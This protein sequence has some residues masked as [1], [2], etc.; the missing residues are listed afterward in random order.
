MVAPATAGPI[1]IS[2]P[3][4]AAAALEDASSSNPGLHPPSLT[5]NPTAPV[6]GAQ[7]KLLRKQNKQDRQQRQLL[8]NFDSVWKRQQGHFQHP[9]S[10]A[11]SSAV[12][13]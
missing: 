12:P 10:K 5:T 2:A 1:C 8:Q 4:V 13:Q 11:G 7:T 9:N 6:T 3:T